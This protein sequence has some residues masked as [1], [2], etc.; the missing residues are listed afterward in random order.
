MLGENS[1][2]ESDLD[3]VDA[4]EPTLTPP[5]TKLFQRLVDIFHICL[6][7]K[8]K[9]SPTEMLPPA[10]WGPAEEA[11]KGREPRYE[12][13]WNLRICSEVEGYLDEDAT[14]EPVQHLDRCKDLLRAFRANRTR[15]RRRTCR[16][17]C[18]FHGSFKAVHISSAE[19]VFSCGHMCIFANG[20]VRGR[21]PITAPKG[22]SALC[23]FVLFPPFL[24]S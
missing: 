21:R 20:R 14:W 11:S 22:L 18:K 16:Q 6:L 8:N 10:G 3:L 19:C 23:L 9:L 5:V 15:Q 1:L 12:V 2:R 4:L 7:Q 17:A 13:K 24:F